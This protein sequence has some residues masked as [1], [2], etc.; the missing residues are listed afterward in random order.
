MHETLNA[1]D[2]Y[3]VTII[4][5]GPAGLYASFYA[6]LRELKVKIIESQNQLGGRINEYPEKLLWDVG[7]ITP[8]T[9]LKLINQL[10][11]QG[12]TFNPKLC[13]N[14]TV[15]KIDKSKEGYFIIKTNKRFHFSKSI[16]LATGE[17]ILNYR[18][19]KLKNVK[20]F[21]NSSLFYS[22]KSL[23]HFEGRNILISG[24][25]NAAIDWANELSPIARGVT[26]IYRG[27][28]LKGHEAEISKLTTNHV[29]FIPHTEIME[30]KGQNGN[31]SV[32]KLINNQTR[33][34]TSI[35]VDSIIVN[36]GSYLNQNF[37]NGSKLNIKFINDYF[38]E[39]SSMGETGVPGLYAAG[40]LLRFYGKLPLIAGAFNDAAN[41]V[42]SAKLF[43]E[44]SSRKL[45]RVSSHNKILSEKNKKYLYG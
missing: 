24:G 10:Q 30:L 45:A 18:K 4:G 34:V 12:T 20:Q 40:D 6:G 1:K 41:A 43:L 42:N 25:G 37:L 3:D 7:G 15:N 26:L 32:V 28:K 2:F 31:I 16:I 36:H 35:S 13:L 17:G 23:K 22:V 27:E 21:E 5:G 38:I 9:G 29:T 14:E 19:L 44:P 8:T 11:R 39:G 33:K